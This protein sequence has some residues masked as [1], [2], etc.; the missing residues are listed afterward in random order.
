MSFLAVGLRLV[1]WCSLLLT[2]G[3]DG[4]DTRKRILQPVSRKTKLGMNVFAKRSLLI[5]ISTLCFF[6]L[7]VEE[8]E[9]CKQVI[10][11]CS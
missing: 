7:A 4:C 1:C 10:L 5:I 3:T 8:I 11:C 6:L 2:D 9:T